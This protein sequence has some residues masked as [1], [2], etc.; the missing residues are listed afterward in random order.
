M[1]ELN[2]ASLYMAAAPV[3][4]S[5]IVYGYAKMRETGGASSHLAHAIS[6]AKTRFTPASN[7][8]GSSSTNKWPSKK[9]TSQNDGD[10]DN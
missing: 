4:A 5:V 2:R 10:D 6:K 1:E 3:V 9:S 7:P 8:H